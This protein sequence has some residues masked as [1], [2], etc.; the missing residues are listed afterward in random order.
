MHFVRSCITFLSEG[1]LYRKYM[2]SF[3]NSF[4]KHLKATWD[5]QSISIMSDQ[6]VYENK[7]ANSLGLSHTEIESSKNIYDGTGQRYVDEFSK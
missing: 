1:K 3:D 5:I 4:I 2:E 6:F 7:V